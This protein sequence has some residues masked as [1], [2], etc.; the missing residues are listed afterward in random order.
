MLLGW[1]FVFYVE[2]T[3]SKNTITNPVCY[4]C[5]HKGHISKVCK[6]KTNVGDVYVND[7]IQSNILGGI[8]DVLYIN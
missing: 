2:G 1:I 7:N 3:T 8:N 5:K 6:T 4:Q